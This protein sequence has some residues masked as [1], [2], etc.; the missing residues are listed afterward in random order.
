MS[1]LCV[2]WCLSADVATFK[3]GDHV[4]HPR[5]VVP[6]W[7][8]EMLG[9]RS[10]LGNIRTAHASIKTVKL[11]PFV[12]SKQILRLVDVADMQYDFAE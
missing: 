10:H 4:S 2:I 9:P 7:R 3:I 5:V 12:P 11:A 8:G 6:C 1:S